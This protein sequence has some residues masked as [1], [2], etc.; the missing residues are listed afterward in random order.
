MTIA[1]LARGRPWGV[2][3]TAILLAG[4]G[5]SGEP[6]QLTPLEEHI[7]L[8]PTPVATSLVFDRVAQGYDM[9]CMLTASGDAWC[10]GDNGHG[11]LGAATTQTCSGGFTACS[12]QPVQAAAPMRFASLGPGQIHS[13]G[14]DAAGQAW[15]WGFGVGGQLGDGRSMDSPTPVAVAGDHRFVQVDAGRSSLLSCAL[16]DAGVAW[17]WGPAGGGTLGNGTTDMASSPVQVQAAQPFVSVGAGDDHA[18]ALDAG[19][20]IWCW[21]HNGYGALGQGVPGASLV[22][23]RVVGGHRFAALAVGGVFNCGLDAAGA[24]W[25][26][27]FVAAIGDGGNQHRDVPTAVAGGHVFA[28]ITSGYQHACGLE[29]DGTAWCWGAA[30]L[31]GGGTAQ[32]RS[33]PVA[34]AGGQKFRILRAGGVA[35]CG[36]TTTGAPVCWGGNSMGA[37][38]QANV[39]P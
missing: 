33:V 37:V 13:C 38:G 12:W 17:C 7:Y 29:S 32:D 8:Q 19:G 14:L 27:G 6:R 18:C 1:L 5:G 10:W 16:D 28:S 20:Q 21:G 22:P 4:C 2:I 3:V 30:V 25:C 34:V 36:I 15:C 35:T 31:V 24:A 23:V 11:Q 26:W 9:S 39:D